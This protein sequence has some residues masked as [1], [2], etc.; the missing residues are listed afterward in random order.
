MKPFL[1]SF[2]SDYGAV[3]ALLTLCVFFSVVTYSEQFPTGA[4]A[5]R[6]LAAHVQEQFGKTPRVLIAARDQGDDVIFADELERN[7]ADSGA[8]VMAV[9]KGEPKDARE[10]LLKI[11]ASGGA[12]DVIV[13]TQSTAS[14]LVFAD[15]K[16]D[17]PA[18]G[19]PR[20]LKPRSYGWPN[21]LKSENLLN[22]ANQIAVIAIVAIGMTMVIIT[23][24]IDLSAG[25]LIA[26]AAVLAAMFIRDWAGRSTRRR[27]A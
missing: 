12:L 20:V 24:G 8:R 10:A 9:V 27:W 2:L 17:F 23:G 13:G 14:W 7:L 16:A 18:L 3:F 1:A 4:V 22:I 19:E 5:A 11:V 25:S 26:L 15:L 6:Q 21:F